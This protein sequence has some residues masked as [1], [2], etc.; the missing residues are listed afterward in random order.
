MPATDDDF[1]AQ[2]EL[3]RSRLYTPDQ[4]ALRNSVLTDIAARAA[5]MDDPS[6]GAAPQ[7]AMSKR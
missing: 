3:L 2:K 6:P 4:R 1:R 5:G 7:P